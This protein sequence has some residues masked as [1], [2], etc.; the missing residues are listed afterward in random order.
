[1]IRFFP[2]LALATV[3][4]LAAPEPASSQSPSPEPEKSD[5]PAAGSDQPAAPETTDSGEIEQQTVI[6]APLSETEQ[7]A[8]RL[9]LLLDEIR[10][11]EKE[12]KDADALYMELA[13][14]LQ[15]RRQKLRIALV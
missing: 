8:Q 10:K 7:W 1:M 12:R 11:G 4:F 6:E 2:I 5:V 15:E 3:C 9:D 14:I 13:P